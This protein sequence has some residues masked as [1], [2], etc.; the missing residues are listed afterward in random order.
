MHSL[1]L[2]KRN[3]SEV[4][5]MANRTHK[6]IETRF[7]DEV[8]FK[9]NWVDI[10]D[11]ADKIVEIF[12][13][14]LFEEF[15][16]PN[17]NASKYN[18]LMTLAFLDEP[19]NKL[20]MSILSIFERPMYRFVL[21][22]NQFEPR[23]R[24][25]FSM[26]FLSID[27]GLDYNLI[28]D[29]HENWNYVIV[30]MLNSTDNAVEVYE[31][32]FKKFKK[33]LQEDV[34]KCFI[35][36]VVNK[37]Q[38]T[39]TVNELLAM[40]NRVVFLFGIPEEQVEFFYKY[41]EKRPKSNIT[42]V[43]NDVDFDYFDRFASITLPFRSSHT[44]KRSTKEILNKMIS[45]VSHGLNDEWKSI[46]KDLV[47]FIEYLKHELD[48][49][50]N[51]LNY[52]SKSRLYLKVI[53]TFNRLY[54]FWLKVQLFEPRPQW[55]NVYQCAPGNAVHFGSISKQQ[56][57]S[58]WDYGYGWTC[59]RC[60]QGTYKESTGNSTCA[61]CEDFTVSSTS[62]TR[63]IDPYKPVY[64]CIHNGKSI[65]CLVMTSISC[66]ILLFIVVVL[67]KYCHTPI[68]KSM[69]IWLTSAYLVSQL[70][71]QASYIIFF[72]GRPTSWKCTGYPLVINTFNVVNVTIMITKLQKTL[73]I[74]KQKRRLT[75]EDFL[76]MKFLQL[77]TVIVS[78]IVNLAI[79]VVIYSFKEPSIQYKRT[80][81]L[82]VEIACNTDL[83]FNSC[84]V[85]TMLLY[86]Y[87]FVQAFQGR[88][89][90]GL[91]Y[92][93]MT[94]VYLSFIQIITLSIYFPIYYSRQNDNTNRTVI[95]WVFM[96]VHSLLSILFLF[97][98]KVYILL[99]RKELNNREYVQKQTFQAMKNETATAVL[100]RQRKETSM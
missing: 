17:I 41:R 22:L 77:F 19:L 89:L 45:D 8:F 93:P 28:F 34:T 48:G 76:R 80:D 39:E 83:H 70:C 47:L 63:C 11:D 86:I 62:R 98:K 29:N 23:S 57:G 44:V 46:L 36:K 64:L 1:C 55:C 94:M 20:T 33:R 82:E 95:Q 66:S 81:I 92:E 78:V 3:K 31:R 9:Y 10:C 56:L 26:E 40:K 61:P 68:G 15:E 88:K 90:P 13:E 42:W 54:N 49:L 58:V 87:C 60:P 51:L 4:N 12:V 84:L 74:F 99:W 91:F 50:I 5:I 37:P 71:N 7:A 27:K 35:T 75:K 24:N 69:D 53:Y 32:L 52:P 14:S 96:S 16:E 6:L 85:Y 97:G 21:L 100:N 72:L 73:Y 38:Y 43:F 18:L 65:L 59:R 25:V 2:G 30:L 79:F 67:F